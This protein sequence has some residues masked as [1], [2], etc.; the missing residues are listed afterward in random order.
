MGTNLGGSA[1]LK[2]WTAKTPKIW[3]D[4]GQLQTLIANISG[5][6]NAVDKLKTALSTEKK[7]GELWSTNHRVCAANVY[8]HE[9]NTA[10]AM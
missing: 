2:F 4:F 9:M 10:L 5:T 6:E 1:P 3:R 8:P 7:L